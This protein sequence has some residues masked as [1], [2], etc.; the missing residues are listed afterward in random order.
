[1][2]YILD[3]PASQE[4]LHHVRIAFDRAFQMQTEKG[5]SK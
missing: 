3:V 4:E 2:T 5:A 1:M